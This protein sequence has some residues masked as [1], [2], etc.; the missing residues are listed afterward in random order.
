MWRV[1]GVVL[2]VSASAFAQPGAAPQ[3]TLAEPGAA[4][5]ST[6]VAPPVHERADRFFF[7][8]GVLV[9][10]GDHWIYGAYHAEVGVTI[11]RDPLRVRARLFSTLYGGTVES[12]WGGDFTRFGGGVE[13]RWCTS[14]LSTCLF[15]DLDAGYQRLT[16]D[17]GSGEFVRS[18]NGLIA[19]PR[20]GFDWGGAV[21]LRFALEL[22]EV[23]AKHQSSRGTDEGLN[24]FGTLALSVGLGLQL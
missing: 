1:I 19:G 14:G 22:Y 11:L 5:Q 13:A 17:D 2:L 15:A 10:G 24:A 6:L 12:D 20:L 7:A 23:F 21:R 4:P 9:G 18:D 16:L 8:M 3:S